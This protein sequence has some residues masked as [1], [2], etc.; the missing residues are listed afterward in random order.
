[1]TNPTSKTMR[2]AEQLIAYCD[3]KDLTTKRVVELA[4][5]MCLTVTD[6]QRKM[7]TALLKGN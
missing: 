2:V 7:I 1:M 6:E 5:S 4:E 3:P